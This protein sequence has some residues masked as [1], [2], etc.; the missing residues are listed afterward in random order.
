MHPSHGPCCMHESMSISFLSFFFLKIFYLDYECLVL[1][2]TP[3]FF[4]G[5]SLLVRC[6][7]RLWRLEIRGLGFGDLG[8]RN[9]MGL[10]EN[11]KK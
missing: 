5:F 1:L 11:L 8:C 6:L 10:E 3:N 9:P 2:S 4:F 7:P